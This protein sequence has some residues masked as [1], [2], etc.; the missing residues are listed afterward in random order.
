LIALDTHIL[1]HAHRQASPWHPRASR[2]VRELAEDTAA[3]AIPWPCIHEFLSV[4]TNPRIFPDPSPLQLSLAQID[5]WLSSPSLQL[6]G[7]SS[8]YWD[9]LKATVTEGQIHGARVHDARIAALCQLHGVRELW[10]AD[11]DFSRFPRLRVRNPLV[12]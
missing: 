6:L 11:R 8:I 7:E 9:E 5:A 1:V 4:T 2:A 12:G 10:T 3:W